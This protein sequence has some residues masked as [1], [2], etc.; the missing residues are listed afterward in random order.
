MHIVNIQDARATLSWLIQRALAGEA[1][2]I[3]KAGKPLVRLTPIPPADTCGGEEKG[4]TRTAVDLK[5]IEKE[6]EQLFHG[7]KT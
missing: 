2:I 5:D 6:L 1:I 7:K 4:K 3:A